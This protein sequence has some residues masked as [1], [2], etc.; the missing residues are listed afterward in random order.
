[1]MRPGLWVLVALLAALLGCARSAGPARFA[2]ESIDVPAESSQYVTEARPEGAVGPAADR[3]QNEVADALAG[4]G[5]RAEGD[6]ALMAA[7]S[8]ALNEANKGNS[9]D[10]IA[11]EA[12]ARHFGF[13]G[14]VVGMATFPTQQAELW[15]EQLDRMP[16]NVPLTRY[17]IR[18]APSGRTATIVFGSME[19]RV[20]AIRRAFE[21]GQS[22][23]LKGQVAPR[24]SSCHVYLTRPDGKVEPLDV[25]S[26]DFA[27]TFVL[28]DPGKYQLEIMGDGPSGPVIAFNVPLYVGIPAELP[29]APVPGQV[30][31]PER[32]EARML[33]LLNEARSRAGVSALRP[34]TQLRELALAHSQD[35]VDEGFVGHVSP[36]AGTADDRRRRAGVLVSAF[37]ENIAVAAT[38]EGAHEGLMRSPGHRGIML[39]AD[40]THVGIGATSGDN[41]LVVTMN[42]G[43]RP[44]PALL[45]TGVAQVEAAI[46]ALRAKMKLPAVTVDGV[47]RVA[48]QAG[49]E[50]LSAGGEPSEVGAAVDQAMRREVIRVGQSRSGGCLLT[51]ELLELAQLQEVATLGRPELSRIGIGARLRDDER[52]KRLATVLILEGAPCQ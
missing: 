29:V 50:A 45:P 8:W 21:P 30:V 12:A 10:M 39:R 15:R 3:M 48:A 11:L 16:A 32:A 9:V 17:G 33:E 44:S 36:K 28:Q 14:V 7:A 1:M 35:M 27:A 23:T 51:I 52:G 6:G 41:G 37:G 31:D 26:R 34:D 20:E 18:I 47:Y 25:S 19:A 46:T 4:R 49:A 40:Y 2:G 13:A 5:V 24:F 42:F 22:V 43:R 38:P